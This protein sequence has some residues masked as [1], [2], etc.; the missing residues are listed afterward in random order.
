MWSSNITPG[1]SGTTIHSCESA[2]T[3]RTRSGCSYIAF[4]LET[5]PDATSHA[6]P[7]FITQG[8]D[9]VTKSQQPLVDINPLLQLL[10][11]RS[12]ALQSLTKNYFIGNKNNFLG[13]DI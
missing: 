6:L 3:A 12:S 4:V 2:A 11:L 13:G 9:D 7:R 8:A 5:S 10:A 1:I